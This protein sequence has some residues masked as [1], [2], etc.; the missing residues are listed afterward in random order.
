MTK[1]LPILLHPHPTLQAVAAP[2]PSVDD[3]VRTM[4]DNML[5]TLYGADGVG[6]AAPQVDIP[7]RLV[8]MDIGTELADGKRDYA[9]R[10]PWFLVNPE[11]IAASAEL[12]MHQEGCLSLPGL[13]ADVE[14]PKEVT[15]RYLNRDGASV[16]ETLTGLAAVCVQHEIDHLDGVVFPYRLSKLRRDLT[17]K[18]WQKLR[19]EVVQ[20]GGDFLLQDGKR[21]VPP[22][23]KDLS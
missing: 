9:Q 22:A 11:V 5:A 18:K 7:L 13:W 20:D 23:P 17:L 4:L 10:K 14:R 2:V 1:I 6:L 16:T 12:Q 3:A 8:V 15:V 21:L 19:A